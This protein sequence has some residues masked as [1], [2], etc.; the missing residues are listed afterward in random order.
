MDLDGFGGVFDV[1]MSL[2]QDSMSVGEAVESSSVPR[3]KN[4]GCGI[5]GLVL[6]RGQVKLVVVVV[7]VRVHLALLF[8]PVEKS[9]VD[10]CLKVDWLMRLDSVWIERWSCR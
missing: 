2:L 8:H 10:H 6:I 3:C 4:P 7:K 9:R 5:V 1:S